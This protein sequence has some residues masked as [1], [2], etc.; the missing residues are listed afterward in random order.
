MRLKSER[1]IYAHTLG[2]FSCLMR[3]TYIKAWKTSPYSWKI[4][5]EGRRR[6]TVRCEEAWC[7]VFFLLCS[8]FSPHVLAC[9]G[10]S[11]PR[12]A[13]VCWPGTTGWATGREEFQLPWASARALMDPSLLCRGAGD[14][15]VWSCRMRPP[16]LVDGWWGPDPQEKGQEAAGSSDRMLRSGLKA[17]WPLGLQLSEK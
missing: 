5:K 14:I 8:V 6:K 1:C 10:K 15:H 4:R 17:C 3:Y 12:V 11:I 13:Q 7:A 16:S 9:G 2:F